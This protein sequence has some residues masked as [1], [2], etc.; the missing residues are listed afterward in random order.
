MHIDNVDLEHFPTNEVAQR[1]LTYVTRGWYDKSY[2]GKWIF[3]VIGLELDSAI[4]RVEELQNQ[5][6]LEKADWGLYFH[7]LMYG[8][9]MNAADDIEERRR[10][11]LKYRDRSIK[12]PM[13]PSRLENIILSIFG[14]VSSVIEQPEQY[15]FLLNIDWGKVPADLK[16]IYELLK[17]IDSIKPSHIGYTAQLNMAERSKISVGFAVK[18]YKKIKVNNYV[19]SDPLIGINCYVDEDTILLANEDDDLLIV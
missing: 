16:F 12:S 7:E 18:E 5:A 10:T 19:S 11:I 6:F 15:K 14:L 1:L 4:K 13:N 17:L 9:P 2:V 3:E 8:I